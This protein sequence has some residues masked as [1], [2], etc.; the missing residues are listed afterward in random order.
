MD[1]KKSYKKY[2]AAWRD[3]RL[4]DTYSSEATRELCLDSYRQ[5]FNITF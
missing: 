2:K 1:I 5:L 3:I 4:L